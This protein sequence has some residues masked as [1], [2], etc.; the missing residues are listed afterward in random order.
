MVLEL[1]TEKEERLDMEK[2]QEWIKANFLLL[3]VLGVGRRLRSAMQTLSWAL[4]PGRVR[5]Q[6]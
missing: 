5:N 1:I 3:Q 4:I 6:C 2:V